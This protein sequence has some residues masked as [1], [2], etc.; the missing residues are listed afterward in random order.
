MY[1]QT[2]MSQKWPESG[3]ERFD[4]VAACHHAGCRNCRR[5]RKPQAPAGCADHAD[6]A[7]HAK[8]QSPHTHAHSPSALSCAMTVISSPATRLHPFLRNSCN[9]CSD[10]SVHSTDKRVPFSPGSNK[11]CKASCAAEHP[12]PF[13]IMPTVPAPCR[14]FLL[15]ADPWRQ[16]EPRAGTRMPSRHFSSLRSFFEDGIVILNLPFQP[17]RFAV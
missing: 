6:H 11:S 16:T 7:N 8:R 14:H 2:D 4:A 12:S 17:G 5:R 10:R 13:S 1:T 3:G 9:R 15:P